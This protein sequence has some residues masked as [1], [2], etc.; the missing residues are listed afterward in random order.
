MGS[1]TMRAV[2]GSVALVVAVVGNT[3]AWAD[4]EAKSDCDAKK[5]AGRYQIVSGE[6]FGV[7]V[8]EKDYDGS[9]VVFT[10][11]AIVMTDKHQKQS[12]AATF[13]L[14]P[15]EKHCRITMTST[16]AGNQGQRARGL[17][18]K[19][20]D[21]LRLIYALPGGDEPTEFRTKDKQL[22]FVLKPPK[23]AVPQKSSPRSRTG[24]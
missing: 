11:D 22:L 7:K 5:I 23:E 1:E 12:Y 16:L 6:K 15:G 19:Q 17:V 10:T 2:I 24:H 20:G 13:K 9:V 4:D 3:F 14:E 8:P 21:T 18:E